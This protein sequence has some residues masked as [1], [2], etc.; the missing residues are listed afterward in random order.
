MNRHKFALAAVGLVLPSLGAVGV[1]HAQA[2]GGSCHPAY[3]SPCVPNDGQDVDCEGGGGNGPHYVKGPVVLKQVG[4]DPFDLDGTPED[5]KGC[6]VVGGGGGGPAPTSTE[7]APPVT[8][9]VTPTT[10]APTKTPGAVR[11]TPKFTG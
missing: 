1:A 9:G 11:A 4:T 8:R 3:S 2:T 5:G 10:K 6:E 7:P